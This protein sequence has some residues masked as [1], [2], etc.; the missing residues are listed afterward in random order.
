MSRKGRYRKFRPDFEPE[1]WYSDGSD[2]GIQNVRNQNVSITES[3]VE[4]EGEV[5]GRSQAPNGRQDLAGDSD[6]EEETEVRGEETEVRGRSPAP[7]GPI[8]H[9]DKAIN[10]EQIGS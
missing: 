3:N 1:P 2:N 10:L 7:D 8:E 9:E 5:R 6:V 4:E